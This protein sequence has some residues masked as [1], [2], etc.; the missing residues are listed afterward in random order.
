[1][2]VSIITV[3][4]N[5]VSTLEA[6]I[7]SVLSQDHPDIEYIL[8]DGNSTDGSRELI[9]EY[10][11]KHSVRWI[12]EPDRGIY[13]AM[14]KGISMATGDVVGILNAD[15]FYAHNQVISQVADSFR[16]S[17]ADSLYGDLAYVDSGNVQRIVRYWKSGSYRP[18]AF[19]NGWM[20]PHPTFF[21]R[22]EVYQ[23][24]NSF[25]LRLRSA[26]DY[27]LMLRFI[28]KNGISVTYL[29][30]VMVMMRTGGASNANLR[31]RFRANREDR[32]AWQ[33][34]GLEPHP[35]TLMMKPLR[36]VGQYILALWQSPASLTDNRYLTRSGA[37]L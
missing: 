26:A 36:K 13:D 25:D 14:N 16:R 18:G 28:H 10:A 8:V 11:A 37:N 5:A 9:E 24:F 21:V 27:E 33:M 2:K 29:P 7:N 20:P 32:M 34:N 1:M 4:Y 23:K 15:D 17:G 12:S 30:Q 35:L 22:R 6:T 31:N 3:V 19:R